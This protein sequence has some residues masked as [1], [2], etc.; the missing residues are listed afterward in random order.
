MAFRQ[1][2]LRLFQPHFFAKVFRD[3]SSWAATVCMTGSTGRSK[4]FGAF[5]KA[6]L[7]ARPMNFWPMRQMLMVLLSGILWTSANLVEASLT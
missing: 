7:W 6:L 2:V 5:K 4:N 1:S 3:F